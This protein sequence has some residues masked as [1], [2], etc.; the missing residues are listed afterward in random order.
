MAVVAAFEFQNQVALGESARD[1][2]GG[3]GRFGA[4][5]DEAN[6]LDGRHRAGDLLAQFDFER[7]SHAVAGAAPR[8]LGDRGDHVRVRVAQNQRAPGADVIDVLAPVHILEARALRAID[9]QRRAAHGAKRAH[10]AVH[11]ADQNFFGALEKLAERG[12]DSTTLLGI[13]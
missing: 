3:H 7:R 1:A 2:N 6:A 10:G 13:S 9:D 8:L 11:A 12:R 5:A 4:G